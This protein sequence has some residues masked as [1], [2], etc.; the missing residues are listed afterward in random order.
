MNSFQPS[1]R[2]TILMSSI[3]NC[4]GVLTQA[5]GLETAAQCT[6]W[7]PGRWAGPATPEEQWTVQ[8]VAVVVTHYFTLHYIIA[9]TI[10][11]PYK[12]FY[13]YTVIIF[14]THCN[15]GCYYVFIITYYHIII[16]SLLHNITNGNH[17]IIISLLRVMP[18]VSPI[19]KSLLLIITK[20]S[21]II[22]YF[23]LELADD[24]STIPF[25]AQHS[26]C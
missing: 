10:F 24:G 21:T 4:C 2:T 19:I 15:I 6:P 26:H 23:T 1:K 12:V 14:I 13:F 16:T 5:E 25:N 7:I 8:R 9:L 17:V 3:P 11:M 20:G 22:I 18:R